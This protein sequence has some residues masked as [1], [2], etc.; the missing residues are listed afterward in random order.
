M[1]SLRSITVCAGLAAA[2]LASAPAAAE[3]PGW[4]RAALCDID[5]AAMAAAAAPTLAEAGATE[6]TAFGDGG[7]I[8]GRS[9]SHYV[10]FTFDDGPKYSTTPKVLEALDRYDVPGTFFVVGWRFTG[11]GRHSQRNLEVLHDTIARGHHIGNH[12]MSHKN[13]AQVKQEVMAAEIEQAADAI[14]AEVGF[15][16]YLFRPPYGGMNDRARAF[17]AEKGY[18]EARWSIDSSD[19]RA[20]LRKTLRQRVVRRILADEGGVVLMHDTKDATATE[21]AGILDDLEAANCLRLAAGEPLIVPVTMHYFM[22]DE[23]GNPRPIPADVAARTES[24]V[25]AL[26]ARCEART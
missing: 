23:A 2:L 19:F 21:I 24:Y 8:H 5:P 7:T 10:A 13:M 20:E 25:T 22:K 16:P 14:E 26:P 9:P 12:T 1:R 3:S 18:S 17:L 4:L 6:R 15:R 11:K